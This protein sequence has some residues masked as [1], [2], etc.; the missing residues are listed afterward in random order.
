SSAMPG[1]IATLSSALSPSA[2]TTDQLKDLPAGYHALDVAPPA[3]GYGALDA[4]AALPWALTIAQAWAADARLERIDV[5][6]MRP[7]GTLNVQDDAEASVT[8]R[9]KSPSKLAAY[10]E[11]ARLSS[12]T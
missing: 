3:G 2:R 9:F 8:Y 11:Q 5:A 1:A 12:S 10:R 4:V 6:R 7:D